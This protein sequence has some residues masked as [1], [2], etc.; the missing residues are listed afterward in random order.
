A[1]E[2]GLLKPGDLVVLVAA[3]VGYV[4][5]ALCL[6]WGETG[7]GRPNDRDGLRGRRPGRTPEPDG[8]GG[9]AGAP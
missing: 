4:W 9:E 8:V 2:R 7:R 6:R 5:N 3:G 1:E